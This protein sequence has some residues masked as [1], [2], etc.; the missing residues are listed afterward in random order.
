MKMVAEE[1]YNTCALSLKQCYYIDIYDI[2]VYFY[3]IIV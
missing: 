1:K 2:I 3:Y